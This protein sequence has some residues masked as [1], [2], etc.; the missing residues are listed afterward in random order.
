MAI[1]FRYAIRYPNIKNWVY[2]K[3][4]DIIQAAEQGVLPPR[5]MI[6]THPQRWTDK[7]VEWVKEIF[8]QTLKNVVKRILIKIK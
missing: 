1:R 6:T 2:H 8:T 4:D 7:R 5:I 3:T